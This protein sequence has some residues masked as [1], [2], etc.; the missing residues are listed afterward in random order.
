MSPKRKRLRWLRYLFGGLT[1]AV[2]LLIVFYQP[3]LFGLTE[4]VVQQI[5]R[6]Q[7]FTIQFKIHGSIFSNLLIQDL[8]LEPL[9][10]NHT[11]PIER[12]DVGRFSARYSLLSLLQQ[13][14]GEVVHLI[15]LK[16]VN[17][18]IR[19]TPPTTTALPKASPSKGGPL[20]I[21]P[22]I[23]QRIDVSNINIQIRRTEGDW[24]VQN[25]GI[26]LTANRPGSLTCGELALPP[27]ADWKD[28]KADL[29]IQENVLHLTGLSLSPF[30]AIDQLTLDASRLSTGKL[31]GSVAGKTFDA[32][33]R[34]DASLDSQATQNLLVGTI[35]IA[36]LNLQ[37]LQSIIKAPI[38]GSMPILDLSINGDLDHPRSI[39]G[40][41]VLVGDKIRYQ[42]QQIEDLDL[43]VSVAEGKG[44]IDRCLLNAGLNRVSLGGNFLL[45][46]HADT[47][48]DEF[49]AHVGFAAMLLDPARFLPGLQFNGLIAGNAQIAGGNASTTI[50]LFNAGLKQA[51]IAVPRSEATICAVARLPLPEDLRSGFAAV[52]DVGVSDA[53]IDLANIEKIG[54]VIQLQD[55]K[56]NTNVE[57]SSGKSN[58]QLHAELPLPM[59]GATPDLKRL[60]AKV[61][62]HLGSIADFVRE[63]Q[64]NGSFIGDGEITLRNGQPV[65][66]VQF[67]GDNLRY[68]EFA[69]QR[70]TMNANAADGGVKIQQLHAA[71][72]DSNYLEASGEVKL[73]DTYPY[74]GTAVVRLTDLAKLESLLTSLR[75]PA[76]LRGIF[77]MTAKANGDIRQRVPHAEIQANGHDIN[78][79]GLPVQN[80]NLKAKTEQ[81]NAII[82]SAQITFDPHNSLDLNGILNLNAPLH[83]NVSGQIQLD[84]LRVFDSFFKTTGPE[85]NIA[86]R[87][88]AR[89]S[90]NGELNDNR[91]TEARLSLIGTQIKYRGLSLQSTEVSGSVKDNLLTLPT[92]RVIADR[93]DSINLS[94]RGQLA[95]PYEYEGDA[96]V[97]LK[98]LHFLDPLLKSFGQDVGLGGKLNLTWSG[99]G[100]LKNSVGSAQLH[101]SDLE[102]KGTKGIKADLE[103]SYDGMKAE[104]TR[105]QVLS[106]LANLDTTVRFSPELFEIP[107]L[108][109]RKDQNLM[110]GSASIPLD[111]SQKKLPIALDRPLSIDLVADK[112]SLAGFQARNPPITGNAGLTV[113]ASG[114]LKDP[115]IQI[116]TGLTDLRS[117]TAS[118]IAAANGDFSLVLANKVL[119]LDGHF[120]QPEIQP[121]QVQGKLPLDIA[122]VLDSGK[123]PLNTPIALSVHWPETN[124]QFARKLT[125][126]IRVLEGRVAIDANVAGTL[127]K[128]EISGAVSAN[129][130]RFRAATDVVPPISDFAVNLNFRD[131]HRVTFDRFNGLAG[132]GP[133]S[134][135]GSIDLAQGTNPQFDLALTTRKF[136]LTR[137]DNIIV[138][139]NIDLT[140]R[141]PLSTLEIVGKVGLVDSRFFQDIDILPLNLP[142]RPAPQPPSVPPPS[143]VSISTPPVRDWKFNVKVQTDQPFLIQ[144]NLARGQV[145]VD[146]QVGGTGL[147]PTVTGFVRV[148]QLTASLPF[149]HMD[150][151]NGYIDFSPGGNPLNPSFN[152]TGVSLIRDY[153]VRMRVF[154]DVSN[155]QILFDSSPPLA[156]GDIA[157]LLAT[158]STTSEFV[159]DPTLLA[160][161]ASFILAQQLLTKVFKVRPNAQQQSYLERFQ[162]DI[163]PGDRP[164]TQDISARFNLTNNWQLIGDFGQAGNVSGRL[165]YLIRFR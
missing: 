103:A 2:L 112:I 58:A 24:V 106:P 6:S 99:K 55:G 1:V 148:D 130:N 107:H 29:K 11:L 8:H 136:L 151:T 127:E 102:V 140:V 65:G 28:L 63:S 70:I 5:A 3:I 15:E 7:K 134:L 141:G 52:V 83:Y 155:F 36:H 62:F 13:K 119:I 162:V 38:T 118:G 74:E 122:Q 22:I 100:Q 20:R 165:R 96:N 95:E 35:Q 111:L 26:N 138:R 59:P 54:A 27:V 71:V 93:N 142:G 116:K 87:L 143:S 33:L 68:G 164:G 157:T 23:P 160:G 50:H 60:E 61:K 66:S 32:P 80:L 34:I 158:G 108:E 19:P 17:L 120:Q 53:K 37:P 131:N 51:S 125:S 139:S 92:M 42:E 75:Q 85:S 146:L 97:D 18:V 77:E 154:G 129:V 163:I 110:T 124:L 49:V 43:R 40:R 4:F 90:G 39:N 115:T 16:D 144:S 81:E 98:D 114:T 76:G 94:G 133:F 67:N 123:L 12:L 89:F 128:P 137:S 56:S 152:I 25:F 88:S 21:L 73:T 86:G 45:P 69:L 145:T 105:F 47:F 64:L 153:E 147:Q 78:Y 161:R 101:I 10:A 14:P 57:L 150:I 149:S 44:T 117:P 121:L 9:P 132:G 113:K 109:V 84:D 72:D 31:V 30:L 79:C 104:V 82:E 156:Q 48:I 135:T 126:L 41:A 46:T 91:I 159:Q